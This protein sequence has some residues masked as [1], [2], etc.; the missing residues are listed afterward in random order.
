M[1]AVTLRSF[2]SGERG[3]AACRQQFGVFMEPLKTS[4]G[5]LPRPTGW[6]PVPQKPRARDRSVPGSARV[7]RVGFGVSPKQSL[8][9]SAMTRRHR[10]HARRVRYR[11]LLFDTCE[12]MV[13]R[14]S[15]EPERIRG[16]AKR[17]PSVQ[18]AETMGPVSQL[19]ADLAI[20]PT[21]RLRM[22]IV[23]AFR[24]IPF[25]NSAD[26]RSR[27]PPWVIPLRSRWR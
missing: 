22:R 18:S 25:S 6:Q 3:P 11:E 4:L 5:K 9:K 2:P 14:D 16:S 1:R 17:C 26:R 19:H 10:Q 12:E 15:V 24:S 21:P 20:S 23:P 13:G 7:S 8:E 27:A